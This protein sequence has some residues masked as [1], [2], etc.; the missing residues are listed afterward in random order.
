MKNKRPFIISKVVSRPQKTG[1]SQRGDVIEGLMGAA[2]PKPQHR[3]DTERRFQ[4][5]TIHAAPGVHERALELLNA[6]VPRGPIA[7]LGTGSGAFALRLVASG[8]EDVVAV[9]LSPPELAGI[10]TVAGDVSSPS[11]VSTLG[12]ERFRAV[13]ALETIEH[14][15][16]PLGLLR[17]SLEILV[18]G[19]VLLISTP[20]V[21]H[22]YSRLKFLLTGRM[23]L[24]DETAYWSTGHISPT[25]WWLL[26]QHLLQAGFEEA[27]HGYGGGFDTRGVRSLAVPLLQRFLDK[28]PLGVGGQ[29]STLF[30]LAR[31]PLD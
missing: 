5:A 22:P 31:K 20:N 23:W 11:L 29:G 28:P 18:P 8:F 4:G 3:T 12:V 7:D 25:P 17:V 13:A 1:C 21:T 19:G 30:V 10:S 27:R 9:D 6:H 2:L 24:F 26:Q 16:D 15:A 14:L